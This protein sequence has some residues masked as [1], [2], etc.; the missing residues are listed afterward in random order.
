M[1]HAPLSITIGPVLV[2][3]T[4]AG[5]RWSHDVTVAGGGMWH[6][7]EGPRAD[8]GDARWPASP[9]LVE[10]SPTDT[11]HGVAVLGVGLAGRSHFS[12][13]IAPDPAKP[14][15][16]RF[17]IACR[18]KDRPLWLGSTYTDAAG[19]SREIRPVVPAGLSL[20]ATVEWGYSFGADGMDFAAGAVAACDRPGN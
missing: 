9:V 10:L 17:E 8:D 18:V 12:A 7:V 16:V 3:F 13:S 15:R 1:P 5:D 19:K 4:W 14:G 20:P 6:S 11:A 2:R